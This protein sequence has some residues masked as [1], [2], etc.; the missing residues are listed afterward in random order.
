MKK[1]KRRKQGAEGPQK[2][3]KQMQFTGKAGTCLDDCLFCCFSAQQAG[4]I[5]LSTQAHAVPVCEKDP[6]R[7]QATLCPASLLLA[8]VSVKVDVVQ[9]LSTPDPDVTAH[10]AC[11]I[12]TAQLIC[13]IAPSASFPAAAAVAASV[14]EGG[15]LSSQ[16]P[17]KGSGGNSSQQMDT[18]TPAAQQPQSPAQAALAAMHDLSAQQPPGSP[19]AAAAR[20]AALLACLGPEASIPQE[21]LPAVGLHGPN[22][23]NASGSEGIAHAGALAGAAMATGAAGAA[24]TAANVAGVGGAMGATESLEMLLLLLRGLCGGQGQSSA[25][26]AALSQ[27]VVAALNQAVGGSSSTDAPVPPALLQALLLALAA[28][29]HNITAES[30]SVEMHARVWQHAQDALQVSLL[31]LEKADPGIDR[32]PLQTEPCELPEFCRVLN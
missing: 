7:L 9:Q 16:R 15:F 28:T 13:P 1:G 24:G 21:L 14:T 6:E 3:Y 31:K 27:Q 32:Q 20:L 8:I 4:L 19:A 18:A 10:P 23:A 25:L 22:E 11:S 5:I 26:V 30:G 12:C 2:K 29:V 17:S